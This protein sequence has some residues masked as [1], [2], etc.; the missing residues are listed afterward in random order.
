MPT[1]STRIP[2]WWP[3]DEERTLIRSWL[4]EFGGAAY[5]GAYLLG[6]Y[7]AQGLSLQDAAKRVRRELRRQC[8]PFPQ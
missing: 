4:A 6:A 8:P 5:G 3:S 1:P 2:P 7:Q